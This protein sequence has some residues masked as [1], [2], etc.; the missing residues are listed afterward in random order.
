MTAIDRNKRLQMLRRAGG[1]EPAAPPAPAVFVPRP[2]PA[3]GRR[4]FATFCWPA[5]H[6]GRHRALAN[7]MFTTLPRS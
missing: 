6:S 7:P 1:A 2:A 5:K 3:R 4:P